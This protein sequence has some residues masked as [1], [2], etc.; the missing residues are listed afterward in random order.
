M[1]D[2]LNDVRRCLKT[3]ER[4]VVFITITA[5]EVGN[6]TTK[7][8]LLLLWL[9]LPNTQDAFYRWLA[10]SVGIFGGSWWFLVFFFLNYKNYHFYVVCMFFRSSVT[11]VCA[12]VV[13]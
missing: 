7:P 4:I 5:I 12:G 10:L 2:L 3:L 8:Y 6:R 11:Y 13:V 1:N 9:L